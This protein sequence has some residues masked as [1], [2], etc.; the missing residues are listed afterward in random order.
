MTIAPATVDR[1]SLNAMA[2]SDQAMAE[3]PEERALD[4]RAHQ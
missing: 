3:R 1:N 2:G 4:V